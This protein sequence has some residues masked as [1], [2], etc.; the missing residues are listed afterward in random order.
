MAGN[1]YADV[2][3]KGSESRASPSLLLMPG[4]GDCMFHA[5]AQGVGG[6]RFNAQTL[7]FAVVGY[8]RANRAVFEPFIEGDFE[9]Y[10]NAMAVP[11][12]EWGDEP[13]LRAAASVVG[14]RIIVWRDGR[15]YEQYGSPE[16]PQIHLR[17]SGAIGQGHYDLFIVPP[18][19][20]F[21]QL[22]PVPRG[23]QVEEPV[24][25]NTETPREVVPSK[26]AS[27]QPA[28][29]LRETQVKESVTQSAE[30]PRRFVPRGGRPKRG[31][32]MRGR[33]KRTFASHKEAFDVVIASVGAS[34]VV[35]A[36]VLPVAEAAR[37]VQ[38]HPS[39]HAPLMTGAAAEP[40]EGS[41]NSFENERPADTPSASFE[42]VR[43]GRGRGHGRSTRPRPPTRIGC[44]RVLDFGAAPAHWS[45]LMAA[46]PLEG[47]TV[48]PEPEEPADTASVS[49]ERVKRGRE[50][51]AVVILLTEHRPQPKG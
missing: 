50:G 43:R 1:T 37:S 10:L 9:R 26:S 49:T 21:P 48:I 41:V 16:N 20:A 19:S 29:V 44:P 24:A 47:E 4:D 42:I 51:V 5:I 15:V 6:G 33:G 3:N 12:M 17:Y 38:D 13:E 34:E 2:V 31:K 32:T 14:H 28:P 22:A 45:P 11:R 39:S 25:K 8:E 18:M 30:I 27:P 7:R 23:P 35:S 46:V 40:E 36:P